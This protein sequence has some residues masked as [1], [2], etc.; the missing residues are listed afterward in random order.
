MDASLEAR[1]LEMLSLCMAAL[2]GQIMN[3]ED[4]DWGWGGEVS[5]GPST[6]S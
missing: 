5:V 6:A 4:F 1:P 3:F 2:P